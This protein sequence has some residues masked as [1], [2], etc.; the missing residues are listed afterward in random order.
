[1]PLQNCRGSLSSICYQGVA[2]FGN[3]VMSGVKHWPLLCCGDKG[4]I[5]S[6]PL[7]LHEAFISGMMVTLYMDPL[8][9]HCSI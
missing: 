7:S 5:K 6:M 8:N 3:H 1:M 4:E 2:L 9:K